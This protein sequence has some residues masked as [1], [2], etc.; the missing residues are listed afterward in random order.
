MRGISSTQASSHVFPAAPTALLATQHLLQNALS[1]KRL[2]LTSSTQLALL[3][4][5]GL[6][7]R[8]LHLEH[9]SLAM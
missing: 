3:N 7:L 2:L 8:T 1:A 9:V 5:Q 6:T 4:A